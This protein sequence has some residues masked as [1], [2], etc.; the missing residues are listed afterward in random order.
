MCHGAMCLASGVAS[1]SLLGKPY[2]FGEQEAPLS[3][4]TNDMKNFS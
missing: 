1:T 4:G 2:S 3:V